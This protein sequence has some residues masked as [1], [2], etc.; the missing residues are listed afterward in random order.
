MEPYL[1][2]LRGPQLGH[3]VG[4]L[5]IDPRRVVRYR[6]AAVRVALRAAMHHEDGIKEGLRG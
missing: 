3:A 5:R 4:T 2:A 1:D 6:R